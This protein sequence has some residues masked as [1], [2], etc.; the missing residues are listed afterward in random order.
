[1]NLNSVNLSQAINEI[2]MFPMRNYQEAMVFVNYKFQQYQA[3][4]V[5]LLINFLESQVTS[6][7]YQVNQ[8]LTHYQP[9]Y[10]LIERN[11]TYIDILG[12]DV[13]K[14]KQARAIINQY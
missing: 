10:N 11:R 13:D 5:S 7:Q 3:N 12:V 4:D 9:N 14:L 2:N 8:L 1:M 6:L